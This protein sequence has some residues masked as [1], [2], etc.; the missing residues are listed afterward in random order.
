MSKYN[1]QILTLESDWNYF[2][3]E[4][5]VLCN[6]YERKRR[7]LLDEMRSS[8]TS[9]RNVELIQQL[10]Q[11]DNDFFQKKQIINRKIDEAYKAYLKKL[12]E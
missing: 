12:Q 9:Q 7:A 11:M 1:Q 6:E 5:D 4:K 10:G 8:K 3:R 2:K